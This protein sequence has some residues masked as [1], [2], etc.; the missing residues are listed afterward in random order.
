RR[1]VARRETNCGPGSS[2]WQTSTRRAAGIVKPA[3]PEPAA[4]ERARL[5]THR[6]LPTLGSPPTNR[7]PCGGS[8][9]GSI[10]P[11]GGEAGCSV[12]SWARE[13][14]ADFDEFFAAV[15]FI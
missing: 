3:R 2:N 15:S 9:P 10:Q 6:L 13:T 14:T 1:I 4:N 7:M 5:A 11:G 12:S 8:N